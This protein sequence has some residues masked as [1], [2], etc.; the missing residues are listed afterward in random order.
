MEH[1]RV[2]K[3]IFKKSEMKI[4]KKEFYAV[5]KTDSHIQR[6]R[7]DPYLTLYIKINLKQIKDVNIRTETVKLI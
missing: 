1:P 4:S 3:G 7:L 2:L 5:G 6:M